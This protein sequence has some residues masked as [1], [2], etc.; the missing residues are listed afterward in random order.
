MMAGS[1]YVLRRVQTR[2]ICF[3]PKGFPMNTTTTAFPDEV[4]TAVA[5]TV[6]PR[7]RVG[8]KGLARFNMFGSAKTLV[9]KLL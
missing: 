4:R 8:I 6:Q 5:A 3:W 7:R 1:Y 2:C 9:T